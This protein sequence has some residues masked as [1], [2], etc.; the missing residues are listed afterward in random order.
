MLKLAP[1]LT[2]LLYLGNDSLFSTRD[3]PD[4]VLAS[5]RKRLS[6][7]RCIEAHIDG[8]SHPHPYNS[9]SKTAGCAGNRL[10][11]RSNRLGREPFR[12]RRQAGDTGPSCRRRQCQHRGF[13]LQSCSRVSEGC[14]SPSA[15]NA[16]T[17]VRLEVA[18]RP[19]IDWN[20]V[21]HDPYTHPGDHQRPCCPHAATR[22]FAL[23]YSASSHSDGKRD[24]RLRTG[25]PR[26][27]RTT[28]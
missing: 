25:Y 11:H 19:Q 27:R 16:P 28:R 21:A 4:L 13:C 24:P 1:C 23:R 18:S 22:A 10:F 20:K 2:V 15:R 14:R 17:S 5:S 3:L 12:H 9:P 8:L 26:E 7:W 6:F